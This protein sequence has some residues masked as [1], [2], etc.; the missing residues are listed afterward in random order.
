MRESGDYPQAWALLSSGAVTGQ[1]YQQFVAGFT[2]TGAQQLTKLG[3]S[4]PAPERSSTSPART[5]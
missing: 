2:C 5:P 1:T 3:E 4:G